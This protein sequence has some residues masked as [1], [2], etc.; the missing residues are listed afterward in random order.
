MAKSRVKVE[1]A[2]KV[3]KVKKGQVVRLTPST[4]QLLKSHRGSGES[5]DT[6][7][8]NYIESQLADETPVMWTL[9]SKLY[10]SSAEAKGL[11]ITECARSGRPLTHRE[12]PI[13]VRE[14]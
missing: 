11:A 6:A 1:K 9:P 4:I 13:K 10:S 2:K 3:G 7:L 5:W 14:A 8:H 12:I